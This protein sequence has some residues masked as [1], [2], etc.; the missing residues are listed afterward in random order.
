VPDAPLKAMLALVVIGEFTIKRVNIVTSPLNCAKFKNA[1]EFPI[2]LLNSV[3]AALQPMK[4]LAPWSLRLI[5]PDVV[6]LLSSTF[7]PEPLLKT[8]TYAPFT[9]S[10]NRLPCSPD[11][12]FIATVAVFAGVGVL[13]DNLVSMDTSP[14]TCN[15]FNNAV[16]VAIVLLKVEYGVPVPIHVLPPISCKVRSD[17]INAERIYT[18]PPMPA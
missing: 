3:Y 1:V 7:A 16:E 13:T 15:A 10:I 18:L 17:D 12:P 14:L 2:V 4:T 6:A 11:P 5:K 8:L 9:L